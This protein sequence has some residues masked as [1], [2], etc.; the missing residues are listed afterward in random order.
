MATLKR[1]RESEP[2]EPR[3]RHRDEDY[4]A[5]PEIQYEQSVLNRGGYEFIQPV[6][7]AQ[8]PL[9][10]QDSHSRNTASTP[11]AQGI[12][13][14]NN[15]AN[16]ASPH[17]HN[18]QVIAQT[19]LIP[20]SW[21]TP[22][23][24]KRQ[25]LKIKVWERNSQCDS[26]QDASNQRDQVTSD[27]AVVSL[28][29]G[30][31]SGDIA[32][33]TRH[34]PYMFDFESIPREVVRR[35]LQWIDGA[36]D[37]VGQSRVRKVPGIPQDYIKDFANEP[38]P[39]TP[40]DIWKLRHLGYWA[41]YQMYLEF[42]KLNDGIGLIPFQ[43][44]SF[45]DIW[46]EL[47]TKTK[48]LQHAEQIWYRKYKDRE[49]EEED[50]RK[51]AEKKALSTWNQLLI[52][53]SETLLIDHQNRRCRRQ[54]GHVP[55]NG[56]VVG[57]KR[58]AG[59]LGGDTGSSSKKPRIED[60]KV[61]EDNFIEP[62]GSPTPPPHARILTPPPLLFETNGSAIGTKQKAGG[63]EDGDTGGS[64]E[65]P[66]NED[67]KVNG[68][69]FTE[70]PR[71]P[72]PP[73]LVFETNVRDQML[74]HKQG[75][76]VDETPTYTAEHKE[77]GTGAVSKY[78][79]MAATQEAVQKIQKKDAG[80]KKKSRPQ[81]RD[82]AE[83]EDNEKLLYWKK[84]Y[85][86]DKVNLPD[87]PFPKVEDYAANAAGRY[88]CFHKDFAC[89]DRSCKHVC[90]KEGYDTKGLKKAIQKA[91]QTYKSQVERKIEDGD[92][93]RRHKIW[94]KWFNSSL[95]AQKD[96][97]QTKT[98]TTKQSGKVSQNE[99][100]DMPNIANATTPEAQLEVAPTSQPRVNAAAVAA[101]TLAAQQAAE[102][103]QKLKADMK[104]VD[105][106]YKAACR[107]ENRKKYPD[108][109]LLNAWWAAA[110]KELQ[111]LPLTPEERALRER[112][113]GDPSLREKRPIF[114]AIAT[115]QSTAIQSPEQL[116]ETSQQEDDGLEQ[117]ILD[118]LFDDSPDGPE[119]G[120][121]QPP[122][123]E[124]LDP[125]FD[126]PLHGAEQDAGQPQQEGASFGPSFEEAPPGDGREL[127]D[128]DFDEY[129]LNM[130]QDS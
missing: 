16:I 70:P 6:V 91:I 37:Q 106:G 96:P 117:A 9:E 51:D 80:K 71:T 59:E 57:A 75:K 25:V 89:S 122:Q 48:E 52:W 66:R 47:Q 103:E 94:E 85:P 26:P 121:Q 107:R 23:L 50:T 56:S 125:P 101:A 8:T 14:S 123:E 21:P 1:S 110:R 92:L 13:Y 83:A 19:S 60:G 119:A 64:D 86:S 32:D 44:E 35:T 90:C 54:A 49:F 126:V 76:D 31:R 3:K 17:K 20:S 73:P 100:G 104:M 40:N 130:F 24:G 67:D 78:P 65:K 105:Q 29:D 127:D 120:G 4:K 36:R 22:V 124:G 129:L 41:R 115:A 111:G 46:E 30:P 55:K 12:R 62:A 82:L 38:G 87:H 102:R 15:E 63:L 18:A 28:A 116:Q 72:T 43:E 5:G 7:S 81:A 58:K 39:Y 112:P 97:G 108:F 11:I 2:E 98:K 118:C 68:D 84:K 34:T 42:Q 33:G 53:Q 99:A 79:W 109:D 27:T 128:R 45:W 88:Q 74:R 93:D 77:A 61:D 10:S 95:K 113:E 114:K 69:N